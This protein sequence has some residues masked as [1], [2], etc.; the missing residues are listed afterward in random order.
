SNFKDCKDALYQAAKDLYDEQTAEQV[1]E[2]W[3]EVGVE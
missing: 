2:A 1:Y 3:N